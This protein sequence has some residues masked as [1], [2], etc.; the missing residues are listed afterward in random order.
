MGRKL[1]VFAR[2]QVCDV[3]LVAKLVYVLQ[4]LHCARAKGQ[5]LHRVFATF[6]RG[7]EWEPMRRDN[8]LFFPLGSGGVGLMH[9]FVHQLVSRFFF[10]KLAE[11]PLLRTILQERI[12]YHL[13]F[14]LVSTGEVNKKPPWGFLK[15]VVDTFH[16][17][18]ARFSLEYLFSL[19]MTAL[20]NILIHNLFPVPLHRQPYL[21]G[22]RNNV[23]NRVKCMCVLPNAKMVFFK[24]H[25]QTVPVKTWLREK[26]MSIPWS[27]NCRLCNQPDT[28]DHY[29]VLYRDA[30]FFWDVLQRTLKK[31]IDITPST[32]RF[33]PFEDVNR[34]PYDVF[35]L[36]GLFSL[37]KCRMT[38]R[39][40]EPPRPTKSIFRE[41]AA[42]VRS[43]YAAQS[44]PLE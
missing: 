14:L 38:D 20:T 8:L 43:V 35:V 33:L 6:V 44:D 17:L 41:Q 32:I 4:V 22:H 24:L 42:L 13:P 7:S 5:A 34:V 27:D 23:L 28:I 3:F 29:F 16:F 25:S 26:G 31:D 11:H 15:E 12:S 1:S 36:L 40:A 30:V 39:H 9:L 37:R 19:S 18:T 2:A 21:R 10:N